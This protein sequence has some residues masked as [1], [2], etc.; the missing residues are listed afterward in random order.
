MKDILKLVMTHFF[1]ICVAEL[2]FISLVNLFLGIECYSAGYPWQILITGFLTALPS[3]LF[4]FKKE[5]TKKQFLLRF[6]I[7]FIIIE[8][9]V[10]INGIFFGWHTNFVEF[11][12]VFGIVILIYAV[13]VLYTYIILRSKVKS[14]NSALEKFNA[15]EDD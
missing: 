11:L 2:F 12:I 13:V 3:F 9:I 14:I 10:I 7:H 6:T 8:C 4:Y 1:V 15:D 5:P